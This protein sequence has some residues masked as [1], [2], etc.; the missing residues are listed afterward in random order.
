[1]WMNNHGLL[2]GNEGRVQDMIWGLELRAMGGKDDDI[3]DDDGDGDD[4]EDE[5]GEVNVKLWI[6]KLI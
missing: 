4:D 3:D 5:D 2:A 6:N 1:M